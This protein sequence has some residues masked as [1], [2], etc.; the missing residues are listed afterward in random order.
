MAQPS[1]ISFVQ[2]TDQPLCLDSYVQRV[3][4]P[5]AGAIA[6]FSGVTRNNFNG[7]AVLE[8]AYEAYTPMAE[9]KLQVSRL[10]PSRSTNWQE[11]TRLRGYCFCLFYIFSIASCLAGGV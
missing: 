11:H 5:T 8:L 10:I 6:T 3:S 9:K 7:K 4:D 1:P 2:V